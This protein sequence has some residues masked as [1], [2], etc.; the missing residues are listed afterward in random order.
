MPITEK[1]TMRIGQH[2][3]SGALSASFAWCES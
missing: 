1:K 3:L 2:A